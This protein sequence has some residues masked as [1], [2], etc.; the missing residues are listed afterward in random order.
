METEASSNQH[1]LSPPT[2][3]LAARTEPCALCT[4][5]M[6]DGTAHRANG[7]LVC[8]ACAG[9]LGRELAA[10][11]ARP[12]DHLPAAGLGLVGA[13]IGAA[14]WAGIAVAT[15]FE[16]GYVAVLVGFLAGQG[17]KLGARRA[18]GP[19]LQRLAAGLAV[20][21]LLAAKYLIIG[22][23]AAEAY[24]V[25]P[26]DPVVATFFSENFSSMLSPFDLLWIFLAVGAAYRVPAPTSLAIEGGV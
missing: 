26:F 5:A 6:P 25:S 9:H 1:V 19:S 18:R 3:E 10:E 24:G 13:L 16:V 22:F 17:V 4:A 8:A 15:D 11:T 23:S 7:Q 2:P 21:G 12:R 14:I 20:F